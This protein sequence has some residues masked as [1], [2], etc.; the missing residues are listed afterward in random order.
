MSR[1]ELPAAGS[2]D[3]FM[4]SS[5]GRGDCPTGAT[6]RRQ[7]GRAGG[8]PD[9]GPAREGHRSTMPG[10]RPTVDGIAGSVDPGGSLYALC[11]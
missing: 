10:G 5:S 7:A 11:S 3:R 6:P 4:A 1:N 2:K 9:V 8:A